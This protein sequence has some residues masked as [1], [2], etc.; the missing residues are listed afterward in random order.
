VPCSSSNSLPN[1]IINPV[2]LP[3]PRESP[4]SKGNA[5]GDVGSPG[6]PSTGKKK[7]KKKA[8]NSNNNKPRAANGGA[9]SP[10]LLAV[11]SPTR[12]AANEAANEKCALSEPAAVAASPSSPTSSPSGK[13]LVSPL[14]SPRKMTKKM[15]GLC[16]RCKRRGHITKD[17]DATEEEVADNWQ[18]FSPGKTYSPPPG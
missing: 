7:K 5:T 4:E 12:T 6:S 18:R 17:C 2:L 1:A 10:G 8:N 11:P 3:R 16:Y 13:P 14:L 15:T 9:T